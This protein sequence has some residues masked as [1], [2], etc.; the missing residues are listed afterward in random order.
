MEYQIPQGHQAKDIKTVNPEDYIPASSLIFP[1]AETVTPRSQ[2]FREFYDPNKARK[3][4]ASK[5][6]MYN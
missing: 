1:V 4:Q 2:S 6:K 3:V 5:E